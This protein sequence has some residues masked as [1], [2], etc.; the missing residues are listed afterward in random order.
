MLRNVPCLQVPSDNERRHA[1]IV[2]ALIS[3]TPK[4]HE[5][6]LGGFPFPEI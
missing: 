4:W 3:G 1:G 2:G 5:R 6:D